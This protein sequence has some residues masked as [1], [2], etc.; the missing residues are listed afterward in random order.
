[1]ERH[2]E[3][4]TAT[5]GRHFVLTLKGVT[6]VASYRCYQVG[7]TLD[8]G[9]ADE[10]TAHHSDVENGYVIEVDDPSWVTLPGYRA[11]YNIVRAGET[12]VLDVNR[13]IF[14]DKEMAELTAKE[15]NE[16]PW[17]DDERAYVI[18]AIY[19]GKAPKPCRTT[20]KGERILNMDYWTYARPVGT[21]VEEEIA[22]DAANCVP[23]K[24]FMSG[25]IQCG[26][27][28]D[29]VKEGARYAT[30]IKVGDKIWEWRGDCLAGH[31][32]V[33]GT[34]IPYI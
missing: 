17:R 1:M 4:F 27:P 2:G 16:Q 12:Y 25:F 19:E 9:F 15:F 20:P 6:E 21:L 28:A 7:D 26:E 13:R 10:Y 31:K 33:S 23:P 22:M 3:Y 11:V 32:E 34:P 29:H 14:H 30:F 18:D 8:Y 5:K 24:T